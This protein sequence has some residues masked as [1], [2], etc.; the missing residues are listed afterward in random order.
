[1]KKSG[2]HILANFGQHPFVYNIDDVIRVRV[3]A[4]PPPLGL[5]AADAGAGATGKDTDGD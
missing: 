4:A 2:E 5:S 3:Q 1:M